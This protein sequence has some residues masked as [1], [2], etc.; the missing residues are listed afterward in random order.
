VPKRWV[1]ENTTRA[2]QIVVLNFPGGDY[3]GRRTDA[4]GVSQPFVVTETGGN[5]VAGVFVAS[6][7]ASTA[8][9]ESLT[10]TR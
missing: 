8:T 4:A 7:L 2:F 3:A 1:I 5:G 9:A 6:T 10:V